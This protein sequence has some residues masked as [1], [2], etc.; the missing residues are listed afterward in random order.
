[1]NVLLRIFSESPLKNM[2]SGGLGDANVHVHVPLG[3]AAEGGA[4]GSGTAAQHT[5]Q[6]ACWAQQYM[7]DTRAHLRLAVTI[8]GGLPR[9]WVG[10]GARV[11]GA[12]SLEERT[13]FYS[14]HT[15]PH[16]TLHL[17]KSIEAKSLEP[18]PLRRAL[19]RRHA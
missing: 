15:T 18:R 9:P 13:L 5:H 8:R 3:A 12:K 11:G 10:G 17:N 4:C 2:L 19:R 7:F 1:M 14:A 6:A 16:T